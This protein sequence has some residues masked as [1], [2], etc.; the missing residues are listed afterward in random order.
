MI[1]RSP[2]KLLFGLH[3]DDFLKLVGTI[4]LRVTNL[5]FQ[6]LFIDSELQFSGLTRWKTDIFYPTRSMDFPIY[7]LISFGYQDIPRDVYDSTGVK[8]LRFSDRG[9]IIEG[10]VGISPIRFLNLEGKISFQY[11]NMSLDVGEIGEDLETANQNIVAFVGDIDFDL[12]D[13]VLVPRKGLRAAAKLEMSSKEV[14]SSFSYVRLSSFLDYYLTPVKAHTFRFNSWYLQ[15][16]EE[17]PFYKTLFFI[18]GPQ[19]FYGL[20]YTQGMGTQFLTLRFDYRYE[21]LPNTFLKG[22]V[23]TSP[24]YQIGLP[25]NTQTGEALWGYGFGLMYNSMLGP[26]EFQFAW[27]DKTLYN[28]GEKVF[29]FYFIAGYKLR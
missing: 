5:L 12:L 21:F 15:S 13:N 4:G 19:T 20:A 29:R 2:Y 3:Y 18:G 11:P 1:E 14:G 25:G 27:G 23:N 24:V 17:E 6:G 10:G 7:P 22:I 8:I 9:W 28:P 26:V 16:W